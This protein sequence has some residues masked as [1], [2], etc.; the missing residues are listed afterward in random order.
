MGIVCLAL[1]LWNILPWYLGKPSSP[2]SA[3]TAN[4]LRVVLANVYAG[5]RQHEKFVEFINREKPDIIVVI[6]YSR[7]WAGGLEGLHADYPFRLARPRQDNFGI[8]LFSRRPLIEPRFQEFGPAGVPSIVASMQMGQRPV[9]RIA[10]FFLA[11]CSERRSIDL[12]ARR[13]L[14]TLLRLASAEKRPAR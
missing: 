6:E 13:S 12:A 1:N 5:N 11:D 8:A 14:S 2:P 4:K 9:T 3:E 7:G 10:T